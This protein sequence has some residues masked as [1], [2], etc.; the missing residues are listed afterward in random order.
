[1]QHEARREAKSKRALRALAEAIAADLWQQSTGSP[2]PP[3]EADN[4]GSS[5]TC[6]NGDP[7]SNRHNHHEGVDDGN[8]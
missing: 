8:H 1:M 5:E 2:A 3:N 4:A 7:T 6:P